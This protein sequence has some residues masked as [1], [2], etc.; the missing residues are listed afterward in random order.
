MPVKFNQYW[1]VIP[2]FICEARVREYETLI[3]TL[4]SKEFRKAKTGLKKLVENYQS[5]LLPFHVQKVKG[6]KSASYNIIN[7]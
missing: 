5:R 1:T 4:Q 2:N 3:D 7:S 6:Y